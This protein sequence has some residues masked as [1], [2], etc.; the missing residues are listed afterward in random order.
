MLFPLWSSSTHLKDIFL[1][2]FL[3]VGFIRAEFTL[4]RGYYACY[5]YS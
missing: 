2:V 4:R 5:L 1:R 3:V